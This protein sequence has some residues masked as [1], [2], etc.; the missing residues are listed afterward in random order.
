MIWRVGFGEEHDKGHSKEHVYSKKDES[1]DD[2]D[3]VLEEEGGNDAVGGE[4]E[5]DTAMHS[6]YI[7]LEE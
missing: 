1:D 3:G 6:S 5:G 7:F 2:E 4:G